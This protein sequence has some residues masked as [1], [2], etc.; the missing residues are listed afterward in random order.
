[1]TYRFSKPVDERFSRLCGLALI[2]ATLLTLG[3]SVL[4]A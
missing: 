4:M 1:M 2:A 3:V